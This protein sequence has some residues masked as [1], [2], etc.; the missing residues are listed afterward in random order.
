[1]SSNT[2]RHS[3]IQLHSRCKEKWEG[4]MAFIDWG[5]LA[6]AWC[7]WQYFFCFFCFFSL[8]LSTRV[9]LARVALFPFLGRQYA[10][11]TTGMTRSFHDKTL[12][13]A[14][15]GERV[16]NVCVLEGCT[17]RVGSRSKNKY[18]FQESNLHNDTR[19]CH[20]RVAKTAS[21]PSVGKV[22]GRYFRF[23]ITMIASLPSFS[24]NILYFLR[25]CNLIISSYVP[26]R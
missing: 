4:I 7:W 16:S 20:I 6:H 8:S 18:L 11:M 3:Q 2:C 15:A 14:P 24:R 19:I 17:R 21:R 25:I 13:W 1:M 10:L 23:S 26:R 9:M 12:Q 5:W 22:V